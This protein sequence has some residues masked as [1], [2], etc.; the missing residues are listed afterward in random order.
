M[1]IYSK[2]GANTMHLINVLS[3]IVCNTLLDPNELEKARR[4]PGAFTRNNGKLPYW[5]VMKLLLQCNKT[6]VSA[7]L[8]K[9]FLEIRRQLGL[10]GSEDISCTQ[11]AFSK[12]RSGI[13]HSLF[14]SCFTR[15]LDFL[16]SKESL[17]HGRR[18]GGRWGTQIIAIDGSKIPLPNRKCLLEKYGGMGR[19]ASSPTAIASIAYDVL[20]C[21]IL[22]A[23]FESLC[24][25][26][27]ELAIR[28]MESIRE[29]QRAHLLYTMFVFDRG[30]ASKNLILFIQNDLK[31]RYLFRLRN[32]FSVE[33]D[34]L[35]APEDKN[36]VA[37]H[38]IYLYDN[39]KT[40]VL[41]FYLP[42]GILET[43]ITN[44]FEMDAE[45]FRTTYFL[46]W[47][48]EGTY[49]LIKEKVGLT[50]FMGWS[51]NSIL[52][53]F[54]ISI[55]LANLSLAIKK[56]TDG[57][58]KHE[59]AECSEKTNKHLYQTNMNELIGCLVRRFPLYMDLFLEGAPT[60][61]LYTIIKDI[62]SFAIR[63]RVIDKKGKDESNPR[64]EP[65]KVKN[66]Y[67]RKRTH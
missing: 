20:N 7:M 66:H 19:D 33:I 16:C 37:D 30:Y 8:D 27:R 15:I 36:G 24:I 31:S 4:R 46:R 1:L 12:A 34:E 63:H 29:H 26:E 65:R 44:D 45:S 22:D 50:C 5:T 13:D 28:H 9:F 51:E 61:K 59:Q 54:W 41:K 38:T 40:R 48:V 2:K 53:E 32:K 55:L 35:S 25:G 57:I 52:Q 56:E 60:S 23:Q 39:I 47:P 11:Q 3:S 14:E 17:S 62:Y 18:I 67:N 64:K 58:L 10:A 43:L 6:T 49:E 42:G 21:R